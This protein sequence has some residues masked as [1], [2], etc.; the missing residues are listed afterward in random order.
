MRW[1]SLLAF[2]RGT[3]HFLSAVPRLLSL[4]RATSFNLTNVGRFFSNLEEVMKRYG[5]SAKDIWNADE[6][7]I[8]TVQNP[9]RMLARQGAK[10]V[11]AV[12]S[13]E[14]GSLVTTMVAINVLG[15]TIPSHF[16]L[17]K[18]ELP[19]SLQVID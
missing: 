11:G 16:Y 1:Q 19:S 8:T 14:R 17:P 15:N 10:Q 13:G 18:E 6:T 2:F 7:G 12:T 5:F 3:L 4:E 9:G